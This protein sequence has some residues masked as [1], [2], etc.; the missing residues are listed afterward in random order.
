MVN[1][2]I[3][4]KSPPNIDLVENSEITVDNTYAKQLKGAEITLDP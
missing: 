2:Y 3:H 1:A 4:V